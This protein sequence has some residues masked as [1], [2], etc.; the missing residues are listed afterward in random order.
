MILAQLEQKHEALLAELKSQLANTNRKQAPESPLNESNGSQ[1]PEEIQQ[2][3]SP[4]LGD[5]GDPS[6]GSASPSGPTSRLARQSSTSPQGTRRKGRAG[7]GPVFASVQHS[8]SLQDLGRI[9]KLRHTIDGPYFEVFF[10]MVIV[11]SAI[12]MVWR[13]NTVA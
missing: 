4:V 12:I 7:G 2:P 13:C 1:P 8:H 11:V 5:P 9:T 6:P 3:N 10:G